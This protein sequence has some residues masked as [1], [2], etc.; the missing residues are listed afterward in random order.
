MSRDKQIKA[1]L[2]LLKPENSAACQ[3]LL[4][5]ALD[6][7]ESD[8]AQTRHEK[9]VASKESRNALKAYRAAVDRTR[10]AYSKL[11]GGMREKLRFLGNLEQ[12]PPP[13]FAALLAICDRALQ[14]SRSPARAD[15][16][17]FSSA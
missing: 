5:T 6:A 13:D 17:K 7:V 10:V 4:A 9:D 8:K 1:G 14:P 15:F 11:P 16:D 3:R 12:I 2:K